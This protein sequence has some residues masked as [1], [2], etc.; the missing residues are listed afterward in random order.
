[1]GEPGEQVELARVAR[2]GG[3]ADQRHEDRDQRE[4]HRDRRGGQRVRAGEPGH[5][6]GRHHRGQHQLGEVAGEVSVE[7]VDAPGAQGGDLA[8]ALR[9]Q[10][11]RP[12]PYQMVQQP[13]PEL[14]LDR[15]GRAV[16]GGLL[17]PGQQGP[18]DDH[19][20]EGGQRRTDRPAVEERRADRVGQQRRL[21]HDQAGGRYADGDA[22][23][24][25]AAGGPGVPDQPRVERF[26]D[27]VR[28]GRAGGLGCAGR[29]GRPASASDVASGRIGAGPAP[30][31]TAVGISSRPMRLR[32]TQY[33]QPS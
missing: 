12:Q 19:D 6:D 20:R 29:P 32:N 14:A 3:P 1:M 8:G 27:P 11:A 16:G 30:C 5:Y 26:H 31:G 2:L 25:V 17:H 28:P 15:G 24:Q 21:G 4:G 33:D 18:G 9:A 22:D 13:L 7:R 10:P 23:G